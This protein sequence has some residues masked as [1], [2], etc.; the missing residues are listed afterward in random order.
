M[1]FYLLLL[2]ILSTAEFAKDLQLIDD[3]LKKGEFKEVLRLSSS[4]IQRAEKVGDWNAKGRALIYKAQASH[5]L[6]HAK[7]MKDFIE[8]ATAVFK[9]RFR[10]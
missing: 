3:Q 8:K 7:Q 2:V 5:S 9:A 10:T 6:G 1:K 4:V